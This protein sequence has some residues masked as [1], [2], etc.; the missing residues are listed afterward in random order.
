MN[1]TMRTNSKLKATGSG[2]APA[3][4]GD[5][6]FHVSDQ[7]AVDPAG[8]RKPQS[9][10]Q[11]AGTVP[12]PGRTLVIVGVVACPCVPCPGVPALV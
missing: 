1:T 8:G 2:F 4:Q 5:A 7:A 6:L 10:A 11:V 3:R 9:P 12:T